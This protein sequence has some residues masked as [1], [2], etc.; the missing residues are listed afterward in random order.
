MPRS[1]HADALYHSSLIILQW[2]VILPCF[3]LK[4]LC[5]YFS[6]ACNPRWM[7]LLLCFRIVMLQYMHFFYTYMCID[8]L[9]CCQSYSITELIWF[10]EADQ[11]IYIY[12]AVD[13]MDAIAISCT[14][15]TSSCHYIYFCIM[16][17][18]YIIIWRG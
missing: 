12:G 17:R 11:Y 13:T 2:M 6:G 8:S 10:G 1:N 7:L 4:L 16:H 15:I 3:G 18:N 9:C 5:L 14:G